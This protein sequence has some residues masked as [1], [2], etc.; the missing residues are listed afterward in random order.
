[1]RTRNR[2]LI[3]AALSGTAFVGL[4][5]Y[6]VRSVQRFEDLD[7]EEVDKPG[8]ELAVDDTRIHFVQAGE[9]PAV[10]LVHGFGGS[11]FSFRHTIPELARHFRVIAPDLKGFGLSERP[12]TGDYSLSAQASLVNGLMERLG[13]E[14]ATV[15]GHSMGGQV[16]MRL[17]VDFPQK[18]ERLIL[19]DS[20]TYGLVHRAARVSFFLRPLLPLAALF[21]LHNRRSRRTILRSAVHDPAYLTPEV[22]EGYFRPTR[23]RGHLTAL[24]RLLV[25]RRADPPLD[26]SAVTQPTLILWG[27]Q[28]RWLPPSQGQRLHEQIRDSRLVLIPRAGHLPLEEQPEESNWAI[29][30]FLRES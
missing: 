24:G 23:M 9:G 26:P 5:A 22:L 12:P 29:L 25:D 15:L 4:Y 30:D 8:G 27:E 18:V 10:I 1:V 7:P 21:I 28:D 3:L 20:A 11:T 14:R 6:A 13:I 19:V 2:A 17:A 16:A